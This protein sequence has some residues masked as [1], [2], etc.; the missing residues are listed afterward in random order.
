MLKP[1]ARP[2]VIAPFH[3]VCRRQH[4]PPGQ[5]RR[6]APRDDGSGRGPCPAA[7]LSHHA[8]RSS[9]RSRCRRRPGSHCRR[10]IGATDQPPTDGPDDAYAPTFFPN[11]T[12]ID[13]AQLLRVHA[14]QELFGLESPSP[15]VR[16]VR[17]DPGGRYHIERLPP[18]DY[19][20]LALEP[21][22]S[23][24]RGIGQRPAPPGPELLERLWSQATP[25]QLADGEQQVLNL[26]L[27]RT[28][29]GLAPGR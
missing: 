5:S 26:S 14:G 25:F 3:T 19:L 16:R 22:P 17:A 10:P 29:P 8:C 6:C 18:A 12:S 21:L 2:F 7:R 28:P 1:D 15:F 20:A 11:A 23:T 4:A 9:H 24:A 27:A 13:G